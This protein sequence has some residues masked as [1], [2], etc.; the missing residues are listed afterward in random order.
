MTST[1]AFPARRADHRRFPKAP[2]LARRNLGHFVSVAA[3]ASLFTLL[4]VTEPEIASPLDSL[5]IDLAAPQG[6]TRQSED[7]PEMEVSLTQPKPIEQPDL[8]APPP[9]IEKE[10]ENRVRQVEQKQNA[11]PSD[12]RQEASVKHRLGAEGSRASA[13]S[14]ANYIG[15]L[16]AAIARHTPSVSHLGP[17]TAVCRFAVTSAGA[18]AGVSC[19]GTMPAHAAL[20]RAAILATQTPGPPPGGGLEVR[21]AA[22]FK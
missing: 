20:L 17:G 15:L 13:R 6:A 5:A 19:S 21:Q 7:A 1:A 2:P 16:A 4:A 18:I 9:P 14:R 11:A 12:Q 8:D 10:E 22:E 3:H